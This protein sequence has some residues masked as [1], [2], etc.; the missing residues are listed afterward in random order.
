MMNTQK[1]HTHAP[2]V[3]FGRLLAVSAFGASLALPLS[4]QTAIDFNSSDNGVT[5]ATETGFSGVAIS[6]DQ[7]NNSQ[8]VEVILNASFGNGDFTDVGGNNGSSGEYLATISNDPPAGIGNANIESRSFSAD[9]PSMPD[10]FRD[11]FQSDS[12]PDRKPQIFLDGLAA[13]TYDLT[14]WHT[15][16]GFGDGR[17]T[18]ISVTDSNR[19]DAIVGSVTQTGDTQ[20][21]TPGLTSNTIAGLTYQ[22]ESNGTDAVILKF[23]AGSSDFATVNGFEIAAIPESQSFALIGGSLAF[24]AVMLRR[25]LR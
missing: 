19:T 20:G 5:N 3:G 4:A 22:V 15:N 7:I 2:R 6:A 12:F 21:S 24:L 1:E 11:H 13:G 10:L 8:P 14:T 16:V 23:N 25:R 17:T 18:D 9:T